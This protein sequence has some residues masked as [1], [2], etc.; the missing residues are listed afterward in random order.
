M[1]FVCHMMPKSGFRVLLSNIRINYKIL[2][3][4]LNF[5]FPVKRTN[6]GK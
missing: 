6:T 5:F 3:T 1:F 4:I 2:Y